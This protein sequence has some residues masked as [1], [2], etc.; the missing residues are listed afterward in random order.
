MPASAY[1]NISGSETARDR[2]KAPTSRVRTTRDR[3]RL[4]ALVLPVTARAI[5]S[6]SRSSAYIT[7][8]I[9][10]RAHG[11]NRFQAPQETALGPRQ[12]CVTSYRIG[13]ARDAFGRMRKE[14]LSVLPPVSR[15]DRN[16]NVLLW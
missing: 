12:V 13:R 2:I 11:I 4:A 9:Q 3:F 14:T 5:S 6:K 16:A 10:C 15:A 8:F 7:L 1:A